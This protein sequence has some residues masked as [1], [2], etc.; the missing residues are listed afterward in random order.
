MVVFCLFVC[1]F[2]CFFRVEEIFFLFLA[3]NDVFMINYKKK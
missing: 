2:V 1:L 3:L